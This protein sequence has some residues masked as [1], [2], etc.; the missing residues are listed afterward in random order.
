LATE[1]IIQLTEDGSHTV[2][3]PAMNVTYHSK[4]GAV[5]E[6]MHVF[7]NAGLI[8]SI[9]NIASPV[10]EPI[11]VFEVG[12]GTG[13]N[14]LLSLREAILLNKH[15]SYQTIEL[16]P[17]SNAEILQLNYSSFLDEDMSRSFIAMH[18]CV[19]NKPVLLH[20]LFS[21]EKIQADL[22]QFKAHQQF[23]LVYFDAFD[24]VAQPELWTEFIFKKMF[25]MLFENGILVTYC[26]KGAVQRAMKAAGFRI[27]KLKGPPG[28]R[29]IIRAVK[30]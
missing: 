30:M 28:K 8:Y 29:E 20:P 12:F 4:H 26:S 23:H 18:T 3:L 11:K 5:Q 27:E 10:D 6:S 24:P 7:I 9:Q 1:R 17:L 13:L 15:V 2:S 25:D 16:S 21:F 19:W 22:Q 14:A